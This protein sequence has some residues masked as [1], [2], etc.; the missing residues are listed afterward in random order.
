MIFVV[1]GCFSACSDVGGSNSG[2]KNDLK[3][4]TLTSAKQNKKD[5]IVEKN[6]SVDQNTEKGF[7]AFLK[8]FKSGKPPLC[9]DY[10]DRKFLMDNEHN[11]DGVSRMTNSKSISD[12]YVKEYL[13]LK[14]DS[15][16]D[17]HPDGGVYHFYPICLLINASNYYGIIFEQYLSSNHSSLI[18]YCTFAKNGKLISR[19]LIACCEFAGSDITKSDGSRA[20]WYPVTTGCIKNRHLMSVNDKSAFIRNYKI[21]DNGIINILKN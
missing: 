11:M 7:A 8:L 5:T 16:Y 14:S 4:D 9:F 17:K 21:D 15:I 6:A 2:R 20:P 19:E 12:K 18:Y 10:S 3:T 13:T 1:S